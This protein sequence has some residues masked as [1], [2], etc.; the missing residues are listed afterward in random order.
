MKKSHQ[1]RNRV[2]PPNPWEVG[3][4]LED[5]KKYCLHPAASARACNGSIVKAHSVQEAMLRR[6]AKYGHVYTSDARMSTLV[7]TGG[8]VSY[9]SV[10]VNEAS[11]FTGFCGVHDDR[12]FKPIE[13]SGF[14]ASHEH[15]FLLAYRVQSAENFL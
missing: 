12:T 7:K 6:I 8:I 15:C 3:R 9:R 13:K 11:T 10:G 4:Q 1:D 5:S 2:S 14:I